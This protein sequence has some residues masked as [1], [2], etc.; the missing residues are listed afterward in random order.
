MKIASQE[1]LAQYNRA[2]AVGGL[3]GAAVG[4]VGSAGALYAAKKYYPKIFKGVFPRTFLVLAPIAIVGFTAMEWASRKYESQK[5]GYVKVEGDK[6]VVEA[7]DYSKMSFGQ[8]A[9]H[10]AQRNKYKIIMGGWAASLA[11][12]FWVVNRD[13]FMSKSQKI[14]QARMYAQ[15]L[16]VLMLLGSVALS[17]N[18]EK[19]P[20]VGTNLRQAWEATLD[21]EI[22]RENAAHLPLLLSERRHKA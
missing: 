1:E 11:G 17:V 14:V 16:T 5:Y 10:F 9:S 22:Q 15:G 21:K 3:K 19:K 7:V 20:V 13:K 8:R 12:S 2:I 6:G 4:A 18:Q